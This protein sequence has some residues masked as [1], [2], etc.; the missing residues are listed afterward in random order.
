MLS[1]LFNPGNLFLLYIG[2]TLANVWH[3]KDLYRII[4]EHKKAR[5]VWWEIQIITAILIAI[6]MAW[7]S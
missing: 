6:L 1:T 7:S 5:R 3:F 2:I 4:G